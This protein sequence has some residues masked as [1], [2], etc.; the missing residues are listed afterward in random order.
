MDALAMAGANGGEETLQLR[1]FGLK[2]VFATANGFIRAPKLPANF[3]QGIYLPLGRILLGHQQVG[4]HPL[5][6]SHLRRK[7]STCDQEPG[8]ERALG[9]SETFKMFRRL[10]FLSLE[11]MLLMSGMCR[12][13]GNRGDFFVR[14]PDKT[15]VAECAQ[16]ADWSDDTIW[17][18]KL[19]FRRV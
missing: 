15:G 12:V 3:N 8:L 4:Q 11:R 7:I 19:R 10:G 17:D 9:D 14:S 18:L 1:V 5:L 13:D 16:T 2:R 6:R